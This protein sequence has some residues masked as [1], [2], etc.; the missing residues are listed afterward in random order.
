MI[1]KTSTLPKLADAARF[2][3]I[4]VG[5]G[6]SGIPAAIAAARQG[7]RVALLEE[8]LEPGG[9]PVDEYIT[10]LCGGPRGRAHKHQHGSDRGSAGGY[11]RG[12]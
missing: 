6:A 10:L 2:D 11:R 7:A 12:L 5:A 3:V 9:A 8:H 1:P 4:V